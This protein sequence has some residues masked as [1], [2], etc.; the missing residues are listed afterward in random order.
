MQNN[1]PSETFW[2]YEE[3]GERRGSLDEAQMIELIRTGKLGRRTPVWKTGCSDWLLLDETELRTHL[4]SLSPPPLSGRHV[5]NTLAWVLAFAPLLGY[6]LE[7]IL[8]FALG[9]S[10]RAVQRAMEES[11]YWYVT[12]GLNILLGVLDEK[13]LQKAGHDTQRFRGWVWLVPVYLYLRA[14]YLQHNLS[15]FI[16]W[17]VAFGLLLLA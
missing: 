16:V 3:D 13:R 14:N 6:L 4:D 12:L 5:D 2:F 17:L 15:Y 11:S 7:W 9:S 1:T 10:E 8:A